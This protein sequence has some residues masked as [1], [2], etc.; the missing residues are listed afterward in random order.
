MIQTGRQQG[1]VGM[2]QSLAEH[3]ASEVVDL[4][5]AFE[6]AIDKEQFRGLVQKRQAARAAAPR[7]SATS[8]RGA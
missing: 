6:K 5:E 4:E 2:D 7:A 8:M 1:M 3:V